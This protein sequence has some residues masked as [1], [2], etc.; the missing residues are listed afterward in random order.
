L[1]RAR[2]S[3][4]PLAWDDDPVF[5]SYPTLEDVIAGVRRLDARSDELLRALVR[6][7]RCDPVAAST[8]IVSLSPLAM[9][10][11]T[12]GR[13]QVDEFVGELAMVIGDGATD[14]LPGP[15]LANRLVDRA[16]ARLRRYEYRNRRWCPCDPVGLERSLADDGADLADAAATRVDLERAVRWLSVAG[17]AHSTTSRAWNTAMRLSASGERSRSARWRLKYARQQLRRSAVS[18]LVAL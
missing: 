18:N 17:P 5:R 12:K 13:V 4:S 14:S 16:W 11:C 15:R 8:A 9:A 3:A 10:R 1:S 7:A 6:R 2:L